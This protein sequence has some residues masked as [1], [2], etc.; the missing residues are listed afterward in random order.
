MYSDLA[1]AL[2]TDTNIQVPLPPSFP[3]CAG[4]D[5]EADP[6]V[7][8][9][10]FAHRPLW[11]CARAVKFVHD[12]DPSPQCPPLQTWVQLMEELE[13]WH[14]ERP[15]GFQPMMELEIEDQT[16]ESRQSFPL[17]LYANGGGV[18]ANQLYHAAM[19]LLIHNRPRTARV[20]GLTSAIM[21]PLWH[22]QRICSIALNNDRSECWDPCL[23]ASFLAASR[24]M[25]HESQQQEILRGF[26][27]IQKV[28]GWDAGRLS[29]DLQAEWSLLEM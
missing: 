5:I 29:E 27:R 10:C 15:L 3:Y 8:V 2:A 14:Q 9:F 25:T 1:A 6:F 18:F 11:L 20:N 19:L 21:S 12:E 4:E 7:N 26:E 24:G 22:S 28:T 16:A 13:R 17:V 23:L